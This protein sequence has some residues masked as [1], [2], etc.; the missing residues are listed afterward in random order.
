M[1]FVRCFADLQFETAK[2]F[3]SLGPKA[4]VMQLIEFVCGCSEF[5]DMRLKSARSF[6]VLSRDPC[7]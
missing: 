3:P 6:A 2:Q 1:P 5:Q 4:D 7:L